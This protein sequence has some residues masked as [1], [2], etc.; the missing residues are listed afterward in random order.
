MATIYPWQRAPALRILAAF[1][2]GILLQSSFHFPQRVLFFLLIP[3]LLVLIV[4][5]LIPVH[6]KF[7]LSMITCLSIQL[8]LADTGA[9]LFY[10]QGIEH[11]Q[12]WF[13]YKM[14]DKSFFLATIEE[15]L[16]VKA[17]SFK[18]VASI[19]A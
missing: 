17:N 1:I 5:S 2:A 4:Y 6:W 18:A 8:L 16:A 13:A 3:F 15:P 7:R 14:N 19:S 11:Q 9:I 10:H 12:S